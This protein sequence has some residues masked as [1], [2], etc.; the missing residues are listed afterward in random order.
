MKCKDALLNMQRQQMEEQENL[1]KIYETKFL[2]KGVDVVKGKFFTDF[3]I[4]RRY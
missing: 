2:A 4:C 3:I 1:L